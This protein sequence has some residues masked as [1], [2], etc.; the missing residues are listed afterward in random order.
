M[1]PVMLQVLANNTVGNA[2]LKPTDQ[3]GGTKRPSLRLVRFECKPV[4]ESVLF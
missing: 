4:S 1:W 2:Q 3:Y